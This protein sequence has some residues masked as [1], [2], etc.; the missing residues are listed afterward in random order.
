MNVLFSHHFYN[1][2]LKFIKRVNK[3]V[4]FKSQ[5]YSLLNHKFE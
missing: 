5:I 3:N 4:L 2:K 1:H